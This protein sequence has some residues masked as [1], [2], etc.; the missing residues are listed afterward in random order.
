MQESKELIEAVPKG[1]IVR[2][3]ALMPFADQPSRVT[4]IL[5]RLGNRDFRNRQ[6]EARLLIERTDGIELITEASRNSP[7]QQSRP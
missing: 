1:V 7:C 2:G 5:Q 3:A 4:S 6:T